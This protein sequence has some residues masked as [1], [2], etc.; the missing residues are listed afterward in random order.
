MRTSESSVKQFI[1]LSNLSSF[2]ERRSLCKPSRPRPDTPLFLSSSHGVLWCPR[3]S[4]LHPLR[5]HHQTLTR[6]H[7]WLYLKT[8]TDLNDFIT[9]SQACIK[10]VEQTNKPKAEEK[11][12]GAASVRVYY[13]IVTL[14]M[15]IAYYM[16]LGMTRQ[17][18]SL[19]RAGPIMKYPLKTLPLNHRT[20]RHQ[21]TS[22]I[23]LR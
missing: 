17:R 14:W 11:E 9:P 5:S 19:T 20:T 13:I 8:L 4:L 18:S 15:L 3:T 1:I 2:P 16:S 22:C 6:F 21:K 10:P 23:R 7:G 12:A